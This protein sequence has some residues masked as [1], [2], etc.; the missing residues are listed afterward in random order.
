MN[1]S[2]RICIAWIYVKKYVVAVIA[3][4]LLFRG[5]QLILAPFQYLCASIVARFVNVLIR[6]EFPGHFLLPEHRPIPWVL[7]ESFLAIGIILIVM[8]IFVGLWANTKN[9]NQPA[10]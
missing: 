5:I 6:E 10:G 7:Q 8:G 9:Q 4:Y 3:A 1:G 2:P